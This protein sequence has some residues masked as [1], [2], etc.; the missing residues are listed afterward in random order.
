MVRKRIYG[1]CPNSSVGCTNVHFYRQ[2]NS[3]FCLMRSLVKPV[4][5][6]TEHGNLIFFLQECVTPIQSECLPFSEE[7]GGGS[8]KVADFRRHQLL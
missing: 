4:K 3:N 7:H 2:N 8:R 5:T 1:I 6:E